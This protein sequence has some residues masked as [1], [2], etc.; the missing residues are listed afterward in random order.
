MALAERAMSLP[1]HDATEAFDEAT[2]AL[3][4]LGSSRMLNSLYNG[5]SYSAIKAGIPEVARKYL[6]HALPLAHELGD[7]ASLALVWG[8][9]G[10]EALLSDDV[11]RAERAFVEQ[12][13]ICREAVVT[14]FAGEGLGGLAA[15]ATRR[16]DPGRAAC[17]LG[18][19]TAIGPVGDA[20]VRGQLEKRF[21]APARAQLGAQRWSAAISQVPR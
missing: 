18:A 4:K 20:D 19:A 8:N 2:T 7:P 11:D 3:R 13:R 17:L 21:F 5:G 1:P 14:Q 15:I 9:V 16:G 12:L 6:A 10:L